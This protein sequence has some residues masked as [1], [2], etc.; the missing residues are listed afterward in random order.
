MV[1]HTFPNDYAEIILH[2]YFSIQ[3]ITLGKIKSVGTVDNVNRL[4]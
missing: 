4:N 2:V 3:S 1:H